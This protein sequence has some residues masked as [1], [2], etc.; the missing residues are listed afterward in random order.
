MDGLTLTGVL[1]A[2]LSTLSVGI[3][4]HFVED[5]LPWV[6][7]TLSIV[8]AGG[9]LFFCVWAA[10]EAPDLLVLFLVA[11]A[12]LNLV[13]GFVSTSSRLPSQPA[14]LNVW[15]EPTSDLARLG[16]VHVGTWH[17]Q[18]GGK[19]PEL[20]ILDRPDR[21][22]RITAIGTASQGGIVEV[23]TFLDGGQGLLTTL[24]KRSRLLRPPWHFKQTI[25]V[26]NLT[27]LANLHEEAVTYLE[28]HGVARTINRPG[29]PI[30]AMRSEHQLFRA[31]VKRRWWLIAIQ[32]LV[33][34]L[35]PSRSRRIHEQTDIERQ[36]ERYRESA[37][38]TVNSGGR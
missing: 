17:L 35:T 31:Y 37:G 38:N 26:D 28:A 29:H 14:R 16:W 22:A 13:D 1:I 36:L 12:C 34:Y 8:G 20:T 18:L 7:R 21:T 3:Y 30:D 6:S 4:R 23:Q 25:K 10:M 15:A 19:W 27:D 11:F 5:R 24:N 9:I 32:P 33:V 2:A